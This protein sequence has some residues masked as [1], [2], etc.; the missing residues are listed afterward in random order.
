MQ[1]PSEPQYLLTEA[2]ACKISDTMFKV[3]LLDKPSILYLS[4]LLYLK[5]LHDFSLS[6]YIPSIIFL[7]LRT[8]QERLMNYERLVIGKMT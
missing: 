2:Q 8:M 4:G 5:F 3:C 7:I 1:E 6:L